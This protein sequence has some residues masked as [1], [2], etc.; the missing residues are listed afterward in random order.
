MRRITIRLD[1]ELYDRLVNLADHEHRSLNGELLHLIERAVK[2][3]FAL[4]AERARELS[5]SI[6]STESEK[7]HGSMD[8]A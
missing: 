3:P 1:D 8:S 2:Q 6:A 5:E 7:V 4:D